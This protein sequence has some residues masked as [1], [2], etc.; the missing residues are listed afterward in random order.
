MCS[1]ASDHIWGNVCLRGCRDGDDTRVE[2]FMRSY[3]YMEYATS[4]RC[5]DGCKRGGVG[6]H[7]LFLTLKK[8]AFE[9]NPTAELLRS[10]I[11]AWEEKRYRST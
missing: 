11:F 9:R 1:G 4:K 6:H 10:G 5:L 3:I 2:R 7:K 8:D